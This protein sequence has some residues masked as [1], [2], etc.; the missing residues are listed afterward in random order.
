MTSLILGFPGPP[1]L[2]L[3]QRY[4]SFYDEG[5]TLGPPTKAHCC[6]DSMTFPSFK[7]LTLTNQ[8]P[9]LAFPYW[10]PATAHFFSVTLLTR[11]CFHIFHYISIS[12]NKGVKSHLIHDY[13]FVYLLI[14]FLLVSYNFWLY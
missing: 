9:N 3:K 12:G 13:F 11:Y 10:K 2:C 7:T 5:I 4:F 1:S 6:L 8:L 14:F